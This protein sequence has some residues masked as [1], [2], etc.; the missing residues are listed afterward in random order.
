MYSNLF[1][2][3][4]NGHS[5]PKRIL[6][7]SYSLKVLCVLKFSFQFENA[8]RPFRLFLKSLGPYMKKKICYDFV[9]LFEVSGIDVEGLFSL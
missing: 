5:D 2:S 9:S 6:K 4:Q 8:L 1:K 7:Q 3:E